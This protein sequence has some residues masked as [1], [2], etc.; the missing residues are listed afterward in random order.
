MSDETKPEATAE[1]APQQ[2][3]PQSGELSDEALDAVAG[4]ATYTINI[5]N[6]SPD[7]NRFLVFQKPA[8]APGNHAPIA[9]S[10]LTP[11]R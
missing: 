6:Q 1:H 9:W 10:P 3:G 8:P 2:A 7:T 11:W 5:V 4:G